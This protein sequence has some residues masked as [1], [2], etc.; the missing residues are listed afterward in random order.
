MHAKYNSQSEFSD[1]KFF[2]ILW[3]NPESQA[4][5][6]YIG[7][8]FFNEVLKDN[9][10]DLNYI[11]V[12][13]RI[14]I[15][16][17][18]CPFTGFFFLVW[19]EGVSYRTTGKLNISWMNSRNSHVHSFGERMAS[20]IPGHKP[21]GHI[22]VTPGDLRTCQWEVCSVAHSSK[23]RKKL[24]KSILSLASKKR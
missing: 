22:P 6:D 23:G 14:W 3:R 8:C 18:T 15:S 13:R 12:A 11:Q 7:F 5:F 21:P 2:R 16:L 10:C 17:L 1:C 20:R 9:T 24:S 19:G 4:R